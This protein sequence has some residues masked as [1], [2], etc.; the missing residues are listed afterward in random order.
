MTIT[1]TDFDFSEP[2]V[3]IFTKKRREVYFLVLSFDFGPDLIGNF[4]AFAFVFG[5][6]S[7]KFCQAVGSFDPK[8]GMF[9]LIGNR[10]KSI[11]GLLV[12]QHDNAELQFRNQ[13]HLSNHAT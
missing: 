3:F 12:G 5:F 11:A 9:D 2:C 4:V 8:L 10:G 13:G 1:V 6:P 7:F